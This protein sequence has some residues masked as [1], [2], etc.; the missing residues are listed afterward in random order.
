MGQARLWNVRAFIFIA[1]RGSD[2]DQVLCQWCSMNA[3][4]MVERWKIWGQRCQEVPDNH[5]VTPTT[6]L[7][8]YRWP[9]ALTLSV[10]PK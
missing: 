6:A 5:Q 1:I 2:E 8:I 3:Q 10:S 9:T 4:L 7:S